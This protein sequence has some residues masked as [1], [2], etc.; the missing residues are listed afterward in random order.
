MNLVSFFNVSQTF[1]LKKDK[2]T[3]GKHSKVR[4]T[5]MA[6]GN[7]N[8]ERLPMFIIGKSKNSRCFKGVKRVPCRY[9]A[10]QKSW[11]LSEL[12]EVWVKELVPLQLKYKLL[13]CRKE[14][15]C[16]NFQF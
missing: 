15:S 5:G 4:L 10:Q 11:M 2:C 8:G 13:L 9:R 7:A 6:A 1:H 12:F 14:A 16:Q 3:G